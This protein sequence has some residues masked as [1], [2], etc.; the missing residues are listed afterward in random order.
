MAFADEGLVDVLP[1]RVQRPVAKAT[2][3]QR[4]AL[5]HLD[6]E[7]GRADGRRDQS[8]AVDRCET[9]RGQKPPFG[10]VPAVQRK[11]HEFCNVVRRVEV[12][13]VLVIFDLDV[14]P[15]ALTGVECLVEGGDVVR[16]QAK[17]RVGKGTTGL[18]D[19]GIVVDDEQGVRCLAHVQFHRVSTQLPGRK[20]C[21]NGVLTVSA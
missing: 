21:S 17:R 7:P 18:G 20:E 14:H 3:A 12:R 9:E 16:E 4:S 13:F 1:V 19:S 11:H 2:H 5:G 8:A 6:R 10:L 15:H